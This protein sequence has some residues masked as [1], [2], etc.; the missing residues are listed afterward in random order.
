MEVD[1]EFIIRRCQIGDENALSLLGKATFLE[2]YA[3]SAGAADILTYAETEHTSE[4]YRH[5]LVSSVVHIWVSEVPVVSIKP[6]PTSLFMKTAAVRGLS[7]SASS[8]ASAKN[9]NKSILSHEI[10]HF[11]GLIVRN[12]LTQFA[13][14]SSFGSHSSSCFRRRY[15]TGEKNGT[16]PTV[17]F[18]GKTAQFDIHLQTMGPSYQ[19]TTISKTVTETAMVKLFARSPTYTSFKCGHR[20]GRA[21][22]PRNHRTQARREATMKRPSLWPEVRSSS[23]RASALNCARCSSN[24]SRAFS[25]SE[26]ATMA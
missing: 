8:A 7:T 2:T 3:G 11:E 19:T 24:L 17:P 10:S 26:W 4:S 1:L 25:T 21:A 23:F 18:E 6:K 12:E 15:Q 5:W 9:F 13:F 14:L 20:M 22:Q 16:E